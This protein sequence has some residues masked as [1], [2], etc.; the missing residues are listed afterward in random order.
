MRIAV[1]VTFTVVR[2]TVTLPMPIAVVGTAP[3]TT[4][5]VP[6]D[7][8]VRTTMASIV[9]S[10]RSRRNCA[11]NQ[12]CHLLHCFNRSVLVGVFRLSVRED[13]MSAPVTLANKMWALLKKL[14]RHA[15]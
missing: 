8:S 9:V 10:E 14:T 2:A 7:S 4:T 11:Q 1:A 15:G 13:P 5:V 3:T 12:D 6:P